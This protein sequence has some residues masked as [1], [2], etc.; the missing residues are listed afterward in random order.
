ME[1]LTAR[2]STAIRVCIFVLLVGL[3]VQPAGST[4]KGSIKRNCDLE[5]FGTL[6]DAHR[7]PWIDGWWVTGKIQVARMPQVTR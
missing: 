4:A 5:V 2:N 3:F 1:I 6:V 7:Y